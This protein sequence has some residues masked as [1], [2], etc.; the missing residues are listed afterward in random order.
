MA[1]RA[2]K[3]RAFLYEG[4]TQGSTGRDGAV[5]VRDVP[6]AQVLSIGVRGSESRGQIA[7]A[8]DALRAWLGEHREWQVDGPLRTFGYNSSAV[9]GQRRCFEVQGPVKLAGLL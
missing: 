5:E 7:A 2:G 8:E 3:H 9:R 1:W 6:A 4:R